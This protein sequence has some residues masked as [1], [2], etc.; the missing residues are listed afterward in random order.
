MA[1][2]KQK[3]TTIKA[4]LKTLQKG[5]M[6]YDKFHDI[7]VL[8][9][10][11][12]DDLALALR[13][14]VIQRFEYCTDLFWKTLKVYLEE[15]EEINLSVNSPAGIIRAAV[16]ARIITEQQGQK[17]LEMIK[18]RNLTSHIYH[19]ELADHIADNVPDYY[20]LMH[21]IVT[22]LKAYKEL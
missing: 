18:N 5:M 11:S 16:E 8:Q 21:D 4:A 13:D 3:L 2:V 10:E 19:Q 9:D 22:S 14:S 12:I 1:K 20:Q 17:C 7:P 6:L 15:V